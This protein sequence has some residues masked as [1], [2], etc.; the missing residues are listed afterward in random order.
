MSTTYFLLHIS[1]S[2]LR[3]LNTIS[4]IYHFWHIGISWKYFASSKVFHASIFFAL[5]YI[6]FIDYFEPGLSIFPPLPIM[7]SCLISWICVDKLKIIYCYF[8][9]KNLFRTSI[10]FDWALLI[11]FE[12]MNIMWLK[13]SSIWLLIKLDKHYLWMF[14]VKLC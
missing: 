1:D 6:Q 9:W 5:P 4:A 7:S 11:A 8:H 3:F 12:Y 13:V 2:W 14:D 10:W